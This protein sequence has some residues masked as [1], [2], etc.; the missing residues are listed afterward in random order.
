M[1]CPVIEYAPMPEIIPI[2]AA[3]PLYFSALIGL[4]FEENN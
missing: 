1:N 3:Q 4:K 2:M